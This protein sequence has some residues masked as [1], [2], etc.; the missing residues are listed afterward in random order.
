MCGVIGDCVRSCLAFVCC[1]AVGGHCRPPHVGLWNEV[2][3]WTPG[4]P[5]PQLLG[6]GEKVD[7]QRHGALGV[8]RRLLV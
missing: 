4:T 1:K 7:G 8:E 6:A 5:L 2:E 3:Q